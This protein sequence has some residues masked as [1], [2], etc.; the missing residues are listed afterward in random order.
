MGT[1]LPIESRGGGSGGGTTE[2]TR[3]PQAA[4]ANIAITDNCL[5]LTMTDLPRTQRRT[6]SW[7]TPETVRTAHRD[8]ILIDP[9]PRE[10]ITQL[11]HAAQSGDRTSHEALFPLVYKELHALASAQRRRWHGDLTLNATALVHEAYIKLV[12]Q[13]GMAAES[14]GHFFAVAAK[15]MRHI[16]CNYARDRQR[17]KR[18]GG[19]Q[20]VTLDVALDAIPAA[21][22]EE[23]ADQLAA[24]DDALH[25]LS[26]VSERQSR[27]VECRFF[28]GMSIEETAAALD[29]SPAT[30][31]RDWTMARAWLYRELR[32]P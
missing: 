2:T 28:G 26:E 17:L 21:A 25:Q 30:V 12:D 11:L 23:Q 6:L 4:S 32:G 18:G 22:W 13:T 7:I 8:P 14:R 15:A 10:S 31:K 24:L 16:L 5:S 9:T 3:S 20:H 19:A 29:L 1:I 27:I